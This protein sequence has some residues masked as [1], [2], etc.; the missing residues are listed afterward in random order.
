[1]LIVALAAASG[2]GSGGEVL[3]DVQG[4]VMLDGKPLTNGT[5]ITSTDAG[6]GARGELDSQGRFRLSTSEL[7][8]GA[9]PGLHRVAVKAYAPTDPGKPEATPK[10]LVP[11]RYL[12]TDSGLTI[13]VK[14]GEK[15]EVTLELSS[16]AKQNR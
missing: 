8:E 10:P 5:L 11:P 14:A 16:S 7:G 4:R 9:L 13:E 3:A 6:R 2:C 12:N 15:N 1:M